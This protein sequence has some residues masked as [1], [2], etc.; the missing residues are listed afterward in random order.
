MH[1]WS[2]SHEALVGKNTQDWFME[3]WSLLNG[4]THDGV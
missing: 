1:C 2:F 4:T 3:R